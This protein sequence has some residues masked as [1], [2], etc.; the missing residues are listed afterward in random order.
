MKLTNTPH[1]GFA[2]LCEYI[3]LDADYVRRGLIRWMNNVD[4]GAFVTTR[5]SRFFNLP[6]NVSSRERHTCLL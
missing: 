5:S 1:F 4:S 3:D 6:I 2:A